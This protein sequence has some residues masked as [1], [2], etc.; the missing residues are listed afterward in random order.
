MCVCLTILLKRHRSTV[1]ILKSLQGS[2]APLELSSTGRA[3][4]AWRAV[5]EACVDHQISV[6]LTMNLWY[7]PDKGACPLIYPQLAAQEKLPIFSIGR[8]GASKA[9]G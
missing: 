8:T 1:P 5:S 2:V 3:F 4:L 9:S 6:S 7:F